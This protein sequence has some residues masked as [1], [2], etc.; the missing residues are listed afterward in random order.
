MPALDFDECADALMKIFDD[1]TTLTP[2]EVMHAI[3]HTRG[4][5]YELYCVARLLAELSGKGVTASFSSPGPLVFRKSGGHA[6]PTFPHFDL[7][8]PTG[9]FGRLYT[10]IEVRTLGATIGPVADLSAYHEIDVVVLR[11]G[12]LI[13]P[14]HSDLLIGLECKAVA[15]FEKSFVREALGRRRE[16][17]FLQDG[18]D[19]FGDPIRAMP[20]SIYRLVYIDPKGDDYRDSPAMFGV[21]LQ[22]W[23]PTAP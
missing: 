19:P 13:S 10:D 18:V 3:P 23:L 16:L 8:D 1:V 12:H 11:D 6:D 9:V 20:G 22:H 5:V 4:K 17:S 21:D 2:T 7:F 15:D 14:L